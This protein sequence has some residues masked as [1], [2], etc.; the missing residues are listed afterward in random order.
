MVNLF[1]ATPRM[2]LNHDDL[3]YTYDENLP[4]PQELEMG[5]GTDAA[6]SMNA[7]VGLLVAGV[8]V[9]GVFMGVAGRWWYSRRRLKATGPE[10]L[11]RTLDTS[12]IEGEVAGC[13]EKVVQR[14]SAYIEGYHSVIVLHKTRRPIC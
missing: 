7:I 5:G 4:R 10:M 11:F 12:F 13:N 9:L 8:T 2:D 6:L 1:G 3:L 14:L